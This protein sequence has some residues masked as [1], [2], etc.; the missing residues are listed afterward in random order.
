MTTFTA[1]GQA[2]G[3]V[4]KADLHR[5][6]AVALRGAQLQ[7]VAGPGFDHGHRDYVAGFVKNLSH[8][9]LAAE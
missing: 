9:D 5:L 2:A 4:E 3:L 8:P 1:A 7:H 6:V